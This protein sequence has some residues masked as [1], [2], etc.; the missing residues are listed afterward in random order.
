LLRA[1]L[2]GQRQNEQKRGDQQTYGHVSN[3]SR[4]SFHLVTGHQSFNDVPDGTPDFETMSNE[5][6][7]A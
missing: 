2:G 1:F 6:L 7:Q 4:H 3:G 5:P